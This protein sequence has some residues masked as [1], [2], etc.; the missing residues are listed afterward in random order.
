VA[1]L[2]S[3]LQWKPNTLL[4]G[5]AP[6]ADDIE[7]VINRFQDSGT[8]RVRESSTGRRDA[9]EERVRF[10][11][12]SRSEVGHD[13]DGVTKPKNIPCHTSGMAAIDHPDH[14][15]GDVPDGLICGLGFERAEFSFSKDYDAAR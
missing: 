7:L 1:D 15:L 4:I 11:L 13:G 9:D 8:P 10:P 3:A 2:R 5:I 6:P 12:E 14:F